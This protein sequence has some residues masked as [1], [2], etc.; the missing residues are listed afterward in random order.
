MVHYSRDPTGRFAQRPFYPARELDGECER[1]ITALL[2]RKHGRTT[3][4]VD[5]EDLKVLIE[6]EA[7]EL[8][9]YADLS[10]Y[11]PDTQGV[12]EFHP[13]TKPRVEISV[14]LSEDPRR[15]NRL[16]TTLSHEYGHVHFHGPL[17][18]MEP[19]TPDLLRCR[20]DYNTVSG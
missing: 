15:E 6:Q 4:P 19:P 10:H 2:T 13:G 16:R 14:L 17:F 7:D 20:P 5:T 8:D 9:C 12:T 3:F 18:E 1:I 11:G